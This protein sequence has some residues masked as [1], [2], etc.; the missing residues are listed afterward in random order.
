MHRFTWDLRYTGGWMSATQPQATNGPVAAPGTYTVELSSGSWTVKQPLTI[1]EDP[2]VTADGV[3]TA[4]LAA[5][6]EFQLKALAL[7]SDVNH[8]VARV[9]AAQAKMKAEKTEDSDQAR[10][11]KVIADKLITPTIRYSQPA[12][13]THVAYLYS[14]DNRTDQR[15][16]HDAIERYAILRKQVDSIA[17]DLNRVLGPA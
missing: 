2:R 17:A 16:G 9:R 4:D 14:E 7:L 5:Q 13:Q 8:A 12:L 10:Q 3:T 11:L 1:A 15:V 6:L